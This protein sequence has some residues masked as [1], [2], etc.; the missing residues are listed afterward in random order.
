MTEQAPAAHQPLTA[1]AVRHLATLLE[2]CDRNAT[3]SWTTDGG[4]SV[5]SAVARRIGSF[6]GASQTGAQDVR[7]QHLHVSGFIER[8]IPVTDALALLASRDMLVA[9]GKPIKPRV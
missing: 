3:L 7:D 8:W 5:Q 1:V 2:A 6:D 4:E 9:F